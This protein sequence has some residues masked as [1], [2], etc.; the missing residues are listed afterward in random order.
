MTDT[1]WKNEQEA[2]RRGVGLSAAEARREAELAEIE[3]CSRFAAAWG[4]ALVLFLV[5]IVVIG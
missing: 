1:W 4:A 3:A 2:A 5:V